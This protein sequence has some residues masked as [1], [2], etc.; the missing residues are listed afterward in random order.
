MS[1]LNFEIWPIGQFEKDYDVQEAIG[2]GQYGE[3]FLGKKKSNRS[4][5]S[6]NVAIKFLKCSR[7]SEKLRIRD[8]IDILRDLD[9]ENIIKLVSAYEDHDKFIQVLEHLR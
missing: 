9:H 5:L 7:A 3:V 8:E 4:I 1:S 6:S 2:Q